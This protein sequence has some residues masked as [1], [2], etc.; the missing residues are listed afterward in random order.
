MRTLGL[1]GLTDDQRQLAIESSKKAVGNYEELSK[2]LKSKITDKDEIKLFEALELDWLNFK[3]VGLR[4]I[5]HASNLSEESQKELGKIFTI[6]C[7][8]AAIKYQ[9]SLDKYEH[10][11]TNEV[12]QTSSDATALG[13]K[14]NLTNILVSFCGLMTGLFIGVLLAVRI[15]KSIQQIADKISHS[16]QELK[17]S[18]NQATTSASTLSAASIE[19]AASVQETSASLEEVSSMVDVTAKNSRRSKELVDLSLQEVSKGKTTINNMI[20]TM[21]IIDGNTSDI[22]KQVEQNSESMN[23]IVLLINQ[24][25]AKTKVINDIVFQ[26]KLLSFNASV[27]AA[28]AGES[29]KG[30]AVVAEEVGNL[31]AMS[32]KAALEIGS[33]ITSSVTKVDLIAKESS[34]KIKKLIDETKLNVVSGNDVARNC[35]DIFEKIISGVT[36]VSDSVTEISTA[37]SEQSK[38]VS[39]IKEAV[40]QIDEATQSNSLVASESAHSAES[41][42]NHSETLASLVEQLGNT[43]NGE[44]QKRTIQHAPEKESKSSI[45]PSERKL[46]LAVKDDAHPDPNDQRFTEI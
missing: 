3:S 41:L 39:E 23:E 32:G 21:G 24:I 46:H 12:H 4:A 1:T 5:D 20:D 7:P 36:T 6:D 13:E 42:A 17:L 31:A 10:H 37:T 44:A 18:S 9:S 16:A 33:L 40:R 30:F 34:S 2:Q 8:S 28:R 14:I 27:E 45:T 25:E 22:M 43:I 38:G 29:G 35:G 26:T 19:Q 15:S 11:I